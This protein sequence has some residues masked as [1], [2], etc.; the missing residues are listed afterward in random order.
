MRCQCLGDA[1]ELLDG[2]ITL[3]SECGQRFKFAIEYDGGHYHTLEKVTSDTEKSTRV[4]NKYPDMTLL[5]IRQNAPPLPRLADLWP[6][7]IVV[8][9]TDSHPA[10]ILTQVA[11]AL[12]S[13]VPQPW[14][15]IMHN[16]ANE[17]PRCRPPVD[18]ALLEIRAIMDKVYS[19]ARNKLSSLV[20]AAVAD[21]LLKVHGVLGRI[22]KICQE[23]PRLQ[24]EFKIKN[25]QTFM[26][27]GVAA[28]FDDP[29]ALYAILRTLQTEFKIKNLQTFMCN[30]VGAKLDDPE[31]LYA[32]LRIMKA[33]AN[34]DQDALS[35]EEVVKIANDS[36][37]RWT[38]DFAVTARKIKH[39]VKTNWV[40]FVQHP[41]VPHAD[42][43]CA[44]FQSLSKT[45]PGNFKKRAREFGAGSYSDRKKRCKNT[46][47]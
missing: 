44:H 3:R 13:V 14:R 27:D 31:A 47:F 41:F 19:D 36:S 28:R 25:L 10:K 7:C 20:G 12:E 21:A 6:R 34:G 5:R 23:I 40:K 42:R 11:R 35:T 16:V 37:S 45:Q 43:I 33:T 22:D 24:T 29:E 1:H 17:P 26:C 32:I 46:A 2:V 18:A 8:H 39:L 4:L 15:Q 9:V 38:V 30:G